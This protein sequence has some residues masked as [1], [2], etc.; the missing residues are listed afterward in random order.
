MDPVH[1]NILETIRKHSMIPAGARVV[2]A[3]SGGSDSVF[4][5]FALVELKEALDIEP[6]ALHVHHGLRGAEADADAAFCRQL[7]SRL[8]VP[9]LQ[10]SFDVP[11]LAREGGISFEE[12][13]RQARLGAY[14]NSLAHFGAERVA[15]GHN[16]DD[17]AETVLMR[18]LSGTGMEGLSGI[19]P[20]FQNFVVRPMLRIRKTDI[21]E[22]LDAR[23]I[24]YCTDQT[25]RDETHYRNRVRW[26]LM[27]FIKDNFN[28]RVVESLCRLAEIARQET[29]FVGEQVSWHLRSC[30]TVEEDRIA[31]D[32]PGISCL[33]PYLGKMVLREAVGRMGK[34]LDPLPFL[35]TEKMFDLLQMPTGTALKL[36][37]GMSVEKEYNRLLIFRGDQEEAE[38]LPEVPLSFPGEYVIE[39]W[40]IKING[41]YTDDVP[42]DFNGGP[43]VAFLDADLLGEGDYV[44]TTRKKGD[45][46][47]PLGSPG[48][49][50]LKD[51]MIEEKVPRRSRDRLP[52]L[53]KDGVIVWVAGLRP[54]HWFR[55]SPD[56]K[57]VLVVRIEKLPL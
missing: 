13:G 32:V 31:L 52:I 37:G 49:K 28:P 53:V 40:G 24:G 56:T 14:W 45:R 46:F 20:V 19:S 50:K 12:A 9:Y 5:L 8:E 51:F 42:G 2:A 6:C 4:L 23:D 44:L 35:H 22:W 10:E 27:P 18:I 21:L 1:K 48:E 29:D 26:Q 7:T 38:P 11:A 34:N 57:R 25:N 39:E 47:H 17:Q 3:L 30:M 15:T 43:D 41:E 16:A 36:P 33:P 54:S 55:I